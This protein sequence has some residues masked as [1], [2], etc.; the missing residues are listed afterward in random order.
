M[1]SGQSGTLSGWRP[2]PQPSKLGRPNMIPSRGTRPS[3]SETSLPAPL[4][5]GGQVLIYE[6]EALDLQVRLDGQAVW[7]T[8]A[9]NLQGTLTGSRRRRPPDLALPRTSRGILASDE[10][11]TV[12]H[13]AKGIEHIASEN[14]AGVI[15]QKESSPERA[16]KKH[17]LQL[18]NLCSACVAIE[19]C[20]S[21][22]FIGI[23]RHTKSHDVVLRHERHIS[24]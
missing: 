16:P 4:P 14:T 1:G 10:P 20:Q 21:V 11:W 17:H 24:P 6:D 12:Q 22:A 5:P 19:P 23:Q 8:Q 2:P 18:S 15:R 9:G 13:Q 3:M 7:L